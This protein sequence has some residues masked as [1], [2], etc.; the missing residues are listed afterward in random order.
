MVNGEASHIPARLL[1]QPVSGVPFFSREQ[2]Y[3]IGIGLLEHQS[4]ANIAPM[5]CK[6]C[7]RAQRYICRDNNLL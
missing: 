3:L 6:K 5:S 4:E 1:N 7:R 2:F